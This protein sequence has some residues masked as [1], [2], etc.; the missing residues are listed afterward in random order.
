[1]YVNYSTD[2]RL[3][4]GHPVSSDGR[5]VIKKQQPL[6]SAKDFLTYRSLH[7]SQVIMTTRFMIFLSLWFLR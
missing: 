3:L 2:F 5:T 6:K 4:L 7:S 1:M